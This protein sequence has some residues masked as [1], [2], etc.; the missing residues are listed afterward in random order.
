MMESQSGGLM[1][2]DDVISAFVELTF[3]LKHKYVSLM[4]SQPTLEYLLPR[5]DETYYFQ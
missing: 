5:C 2:T 1:T 4:R 3:D